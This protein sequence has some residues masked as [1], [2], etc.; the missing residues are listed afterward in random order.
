MSEHSLIEHEGVVV[1]IQDDHLTVQIEASLA[2]GNCEAKSACMLSDD[3]YRYLEIPCSTAAYKIG[4]RVTVVG[5]SAQR[6]KAAWWGYGLPVLVLLTV[7][8]LSLK[9]FRN[10]L[11]AGLAAFLGLFLYYIGLFLFREHFKKI[12]TFRIKSKA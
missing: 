12:F 5:D 6:L 2:C 7:L 1:N 11:W 8:I 9:V 10:E 4:D 3:G